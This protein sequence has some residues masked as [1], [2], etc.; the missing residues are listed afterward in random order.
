MAIPMGGLGIPI[1]ELSL[2]DPMGVRSVVLHILWRV[3]LSSA[4]RTML[5]SVA[6]LRWTC[7]L[8]SKDR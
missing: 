6:L 1:P 4:E 3:V 7:G 8:V 2:A 5:G